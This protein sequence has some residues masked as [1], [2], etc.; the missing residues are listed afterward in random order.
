MSVLVFTFDS[1][2]ALSWYFNAKS[3]LSMPCITY[4]LLSLMLR[5]CLSMLSWY[6]AILPLPAI[7]SNSSFTPAESSSTIPDRPLYT[8]E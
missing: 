4:S 7:W 1:K 8:D 3:A 2:S 6:S 5:S